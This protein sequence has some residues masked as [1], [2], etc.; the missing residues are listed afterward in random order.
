MQETTLCYIEKDHQYLMLLRNKKPNDL[1]EGKWIGVGGKLEEGETPRQCALREIREETGLTALDLTARGVVHFHSEAWGSEEMYLYTVADFQGELTDCD[2]GQLRWIDKA[3]VFDLKLWDGD[4][5]F[6]QYLIDDA[7][8]FDMTLCYDADDRLRQCIVDGHEEELFDIYHEDGSPA[9]YIAGRGFAHLRGLW[10]ITAHI[11]VVRPAHGTP[12][13]LLQLRSRHKELHPAC[14]D[15][16]SAG[17]IAAGEEL[18]TG[19]IRELSEELG[20]TAAADELQPIGILQSTYDNGD[21]HDREH[22]HVFVYRAD[23]ADSDIRPQES[24]VDG[25]MWLTLDECRR[26]VQRSEF[27]NCIDPRELEMLA[28][29]L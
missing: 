11:W 6:L 27:P 22:C 13:L 23:I 20:L 12:E 3:E 8:Y 15:T 24:E 25:V 1:N 26:A 21:Y 7:P 2:E 14:Y 4:R 28:P 9:R 5:M 17:H 29:L 16:S 10:H 18:L 19:A